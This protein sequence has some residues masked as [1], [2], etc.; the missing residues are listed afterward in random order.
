[1]DQKHPTSKPRKKKAEE[2]SSSAVPAGKTST[3][4]RK[5]AVR[6]R[7]SKVDGEQIR[8]VACDIIS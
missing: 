8:E 7:K 6:P 2:G 5:K 4:I 3:P 1:M